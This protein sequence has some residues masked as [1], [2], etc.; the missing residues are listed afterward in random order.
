MPFIS[1]S[2][3]DIRVEPKFRSERDSQLIY[4]EEVKVIGE[5]GD[6]YYVEG[7]DK[8]KGYALKTLV[9][10]GE[11]KKFKIRKNTR[12]KEMIFPFGAYVSDED[13][14]KFNIPEVV[15]EKLDF[16]LEPSKVSHEFL[17]VPYLWG[18]TSDL[19]YDCSGFTQRL[20]RFDNIEIPRNA[21]WQRDNTETI[22]SFEEA[23]EGD[24]V[25]F[26]GHVG[27]YLGD[28][29]MIHSNLH[30][31]GVSYTNLKDGSDY[32]KL[33]MGIFEKIGRIS[34]SKISLPM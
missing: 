22:D 33:L 8:L 13:V 23:K 20:F 6:Y 27:L 1:F 24:L 30:D 9:S 2:V 18:G 5:K 3:A 29:I 7:P 26:E 32:S 14:S 12:T 21:G 4:G 15:L 11:R 25:F 28:N 31:G 34:T 10:N 19:G 17:S 16:R